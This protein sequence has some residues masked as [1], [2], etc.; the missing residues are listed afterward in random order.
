MVADPFVNVPYLTTC[1][2]YKLKH[3]LMLDLNMS[4][5][6]QVYNNMNASQRISKQLAF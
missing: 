1:D 5:V 4:K 6:T 3:I 2:L